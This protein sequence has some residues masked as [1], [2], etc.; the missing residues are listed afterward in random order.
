MLG[1]IAS[2]DF[3]YKIIFSQDLKDIPQIRKIVQFILSIYL[4]KR[5]LIFE[6]NTLR[7]YLRNKE[8]SRTELP[9]SF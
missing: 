5:Q 8:G 7:I 9:S 3:N 2:Q 6:S 1:D 4:L